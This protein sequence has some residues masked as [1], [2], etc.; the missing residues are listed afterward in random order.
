MDYIPWS[1][2][3]KKWEGKK[4]LNEIIANYNLWK[5]QYEAHQQSLWLNGSRETLVDE[6]QDINYL[7]TENGGNILLED[8][9]YII[10]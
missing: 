6:P 2:Y 10:L 3:Y 7:L 8:G 4:P 1:E 5:F 9:G